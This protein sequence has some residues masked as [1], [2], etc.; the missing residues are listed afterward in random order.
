[1]TT[2]RF[3][4]TL[5][6]T[7]VLFVLNIYIGSVDIPIAI[8]ED[9]TAVSLEVERDTDNLT[10]QRGPHIMQAYCQ[11]KRI[12]AVADQRIQ[13]GHHA[14][15]DQMDVPYLAEQ[16]FQLGSYLGRHSLRFIQN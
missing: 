3:A 2:I 10:D 15:T 13:A 12:Q 11:E 6:L 1:M 16:R 9:Q 14:E 5:L 4:V 8:A 7:G